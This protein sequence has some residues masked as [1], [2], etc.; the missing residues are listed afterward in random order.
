MPW[1][2]ADGIILWRQETKLFR[3]KHEKYIQGLR[4][5]GLKLDVL[6]NNNHSKELKFTNSK[7]RTTLKI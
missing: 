4:F 5:E 3:F 7:N 2:S 1:I 6:E